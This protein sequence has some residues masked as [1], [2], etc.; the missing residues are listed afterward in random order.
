MGVKED[1][2][3]AVWG[4]FDDD[5]E[6]MA[7]GETVAVHTHKFGVVQHLLAPSIGILLIVGILVV[8][9]HS[10]ARFVKRDQKKASLAVD[11]P[12]EYGTI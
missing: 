5:W 8:I 3:D 11:E 1:E 12:A 2:R 6:L 9:L 4:V 7:D 10:T